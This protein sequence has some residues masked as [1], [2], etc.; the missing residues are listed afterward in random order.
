MLLLSLPFKQR[1]ACPHVAVP[2]TIF[3]SLSVPL[4]TQ[5]V[6]SELCRTPVDSPAQMLVKP[7]GKAPAAN[8]VDVKE[9]GLAATLWASQSAS[10]PSMSVPTKPLMIHSRTL[11]A[12]DG[13]DPSSVAH[14]PASVYLAPAGHE[15]S[16][17]ASETA[18]ARRLPLRAAVSRDSFMVTK[19]GALSHSRVIILIF[20]SE[21]DQDVASHA[22][23]SEIA[24][25][26]T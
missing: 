14:S 12:G 5:E 19:P 26:C 24:H 9:P 11:P 8:I 2:P 22:S 21:S 16:P 7:T 15:I 25:C 10:P 1:M 13:Y 23:R 18:R 3:L 4:H 20:L 6:N 17:S